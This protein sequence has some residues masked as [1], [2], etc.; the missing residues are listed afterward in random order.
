VITIFP[1]FIYF[2]AIVNI[3]DTHN[4]KELVEVHKRKVFNTALHYLKHTEEAE[5]I[6]QEV[7]IEVYQSRSKFREQA[8]ISTWI[9]RITVNKCLDHLRAKKRQKRFGFITSLFHPE[10][11]EVLH[12][13]SHYDH[14]GIELEKKEKARFLFQAIDQLPENQKTAFILWHIEE[15]PQKEIA[16]I[17]ESSVKAVES[18]LQRA[19]A[20]LRAELEKLYPDRRNPD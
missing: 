11:G 7:F 13:I 14:P 8:S 15:L 10:S 18:L 17:M 20:K 19:K 3:P 2:C 12:E 9:Y 1:L 4:F 6:T 5:D 16:E